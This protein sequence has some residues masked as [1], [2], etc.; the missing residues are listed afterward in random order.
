MGGYQVL[1]AD[2]HV[3]AFPLSAGTLAPWDLVLEARRQGL[4]VIAITGHNGVTMG[5]IGRWFAQLAGGPTV[6]AGEEI[7]APGYHLLAVGIG[8]TISWRLPAARAIEEVHRQGGVAIAAHPTAS[9]WPA[10]DAEAM[11]T[12][13]ASEVV[14]PLSFAGDPY[15]GEMRQFNARGRFTATA[16]TD[17][18]GLGPMGLCRTYVF[19]HRNSE[20]AVLEALRA[21]R[22]VVYDRGRVFG[23]PVLIELAARDGRLPLASEADGGLA[24]VSRVAGILGLLGVAFI[25]FPRRSAGH[26]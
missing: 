23:D 13:D 24:V 4:D 6:L 25:G 2:F 3:H 17:Y 15:A 19:V 7:H 9:S 11:R 1:A 16:S 14:Q 10:F 20:Q 18:H 21:G 26:G 8:R 22:T 5:R 12:L